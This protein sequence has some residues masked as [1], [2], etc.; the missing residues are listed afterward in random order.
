MPRSSRAIDLDAVLKNNP[1]AYG[2]LLATLQKA[3]MLAW[4]FA[5][6]N[7]YELGVFCVITKDLQ[8]LRLVF[9][10][11]LINTRFVPPPRTALPSP[12]SFVGIETV[13]DKSLLMASGDIANCFY[14]IEMPSELQRMFSL[15]PVAARYARMGGQLLG[16]RRATP[17]GPSRLGA[18]TM[19]SRRPRV[20]TPS[21][22]APWVR[23]PARARRRIRASHRRELLARGGLRRRGVGDIRGGDGPMGGRPF[24]RGGAGGHHAGRKLSCGAQP[25]PREARE[26]LAERGAWLAIGREAS[27]AG[28]AGDRALAL[29]DYMPLAC[30]VATGRARSARV[31]PSLR[32][33]AS[34]RLISRVKV[35]CRWVPTE[36]D[37][38]DRPSRAIEID[39]R[40]FHRPEPRLYAAWRVRPP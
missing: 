35:A 5:S 16:G 11:R 19:R 6:S 39:Q 23:Q 1:V 9:D 29:V 3:G 13:L 37:V 4:D 30:G 21:E 27:L 10:T 31:R 20:A 22:S 7:D 34:L 40:G 12:A 18:I 25:G 24:V 36:W 38:A 17:A 8:H 2:D 14:A 15:K 26:H 32:T 28:P 33:A